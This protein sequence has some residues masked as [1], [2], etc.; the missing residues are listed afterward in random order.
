MGGIKFRNLNNLA[1]TIW[2]WCECRNIWLF[3]SYIRSK[4][5]I[6]ADFESRRLEPETKYSLSNESFQKIVTTFGKPEVDLFAT[7]TNAKCKDYISWGKDPGSIAI[8][9]F[10]VKWD[11]Y[12]FYA[13]PPFALL[14]KVLRKINTDGGRGVL[15]VPHWPTQAWFPMFL[16]ML[17]SKMILLKRHKKM[18]ISFDSQPHPLWHRI[19]LAVGILSGKP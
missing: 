12:F 18:L 19:T 8:D 4:D 15:V 1:K 9:A 11:Q 6:E 17:E 7:R 2:Q 16:K 13:F 14:P 3:A 5:N 10:T